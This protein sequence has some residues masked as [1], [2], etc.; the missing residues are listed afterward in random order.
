M[1]KGRCAETGAIKRT[2]PK[3][4]TSSLTEDRLG[5]KH[6]IFDQGSYAQAISEIIRIAFVPKGYPDRK[7]GDNEV[8]ASKKLFREYILG[9]LENALIPTVRHLDQG[10]CD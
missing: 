4:N 10:W 1:D 8:G 7:L 5:K 3:H 2:R 6:K 9:F